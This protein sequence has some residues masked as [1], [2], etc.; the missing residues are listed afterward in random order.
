MNDCLT[1]SSHQYHTAYKLKEEGAESISYLSHSQT[2]LAL[3]QHHF[4]VVVVILIINYL[5]PQ[6]TLTPLR[7]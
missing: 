7:S 3:I 4:D 1:I 2:I 5:E 6:E